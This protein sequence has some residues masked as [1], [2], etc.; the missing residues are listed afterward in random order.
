[1]FC[2]KCGAQVDNSEKFCGSCGAV[3]GQQSISQTSPY[4]QIASAKPTKTTTNNKLIGIVACA[5]VLVIVIIGAVA[6]FG[7]GGS[8]LSGKYVSTSPTNNVGDTNY[9]QFSGNNKVLVYDHGLSFNGT[10]EIDGSKLTIKYMA[11]GYENRDV[12]TLSNNKKSFT[13]TGYIRGTYVK[14]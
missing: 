7:G 5:I 8:G 4:N 3:V 12:F 1:M 6:I 10:Y 11:L 2:G 13:G 14:K 9:I